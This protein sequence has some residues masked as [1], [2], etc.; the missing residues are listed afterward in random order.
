[1]TRLTSRKPVVKVRQ[2]IGAALVLA[3]LSPLAHAD[4]SEV[5]QDIKRDSKEAAHKTGEAARSFG[6]ATASAAK[7]V[8]HGVAH[9]SREGW[10]ATKRTT[11]RIFHKNDSGESAGKSEKND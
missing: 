4:M 8:G 5:K 2:F 7:A 3:L 10:E 1:M 9:A 6:H 11:K